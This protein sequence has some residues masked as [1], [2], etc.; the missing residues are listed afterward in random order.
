MDRQSD[1]KFSN[2]SD[3]QID[4]RSGSQPD[5]RSNGRFDSQF[6]FLQ[7]GERAA[8]L[9]RRLYEQY[10]YKKYR[11]GKFEEYDFYTNHKDFLSS[12]QILTFTDLDGKLMALKPD[13]TMSI[14]KRTRATEEQ[15]ER[16]YYNESIYRPAKGA[17]EYREIPQIGV[18]YIGAVTAETGLEIVVLALKSLAGINEN[19]ILDVSHDGV[20][21]GLFEG[22]DAPVG[23]K[24]EV[25]GYIE[26]KNIHELSMLLNKYNVDEDI[27]ERLLKLPA[28]GGMSPPPP[29]GRDACHAPDI[30]GQSLL[31][32]GAL[33]LNESMYAALSELHTLHTALAGNPALK[34]LRLDF[35]SFAGDSSYYNGLVMKG[36]IEGSPGAVLSGGRYDPLLRRLGVKGLGAIGFA[37]YLDEVEASAKTAVQ[38]ALKRGAETV[39]RSVLK[40][41]SET[42]N[43][44]GADSPGEIIH[45]ETG[46]AGGKMLRIALP[47]GR[48]GDKAYKM[49]ETSGY[50]CE[51]YSEDSRKLVFVNRASMIS[52]LMVKPQDVAVY[53]ERGAADVG[54]AGKDIL[55]ETAPDIYELLDLAFGKCRLAVAAPG[56]YEDDPGSVLRVA[57]KYPNV[58]RSYYTKQNREIEIIKLNGS[59]ELAPILGISDVIV[60]IVETGS[61]LRENNLFVREEIAPSS[62]RLIANINSYKFMQPEIIEM[63]EKIKTHISRLN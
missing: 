20:L 6:D 56:G 25:S 18:E 14:V 58:A 9:L 5:N 54:V 37:V 7:G 53:V 23:V 10:G 26:Q 30:F 41:G 32:A 44:T 51:G 4:G 38:P 50:G 21:A 57:T 11:M 42:E 12:G 2:Q 43:I 16:L 60:D 34:S 40:R 19:F 28:L 8:F 1:C 39:A 24:R 46:G 33:A 3:S 52:F 36:Y 63:L 13:V 59:I 35:S 49:F 15:P 61:T 48:M 45:A 55:L 22:S 29:G 17:L 31:E 62:A 47:K 27:A